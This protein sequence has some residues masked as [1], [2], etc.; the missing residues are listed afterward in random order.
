MIT[1]KGIPYDYYYFIYLSNIR[2]KRPLTMCTHTMIQVI[3]SAS[4]TKLLKK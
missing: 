3:K 4:Y 1:W 2:A